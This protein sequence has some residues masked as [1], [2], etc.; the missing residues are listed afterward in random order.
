MEFLAIKLYSRNKK[1]K[2]IMQDSI[3]LAILKCVLLCFDIHS[4]YRNVYIEILSLFV[5]VMFLNTVSIK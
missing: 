1:R 2:K 4:P 5:S 3:L